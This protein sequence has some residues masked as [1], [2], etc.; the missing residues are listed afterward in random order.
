VSRR[1]LLTCG[2][3]VV[4]LV[5]GGLLLIRAVDPGQTDATITNPTATSAPSPAISPGAT[6]LPLTRADVDHCPQASDGR[7]GG[8]PLSP[9]LPAQSPRPEPSPTAERMLVCPAGA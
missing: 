4:L 8:D 6:P 2:V 7:I 3:V 9:A 1:T 5:L